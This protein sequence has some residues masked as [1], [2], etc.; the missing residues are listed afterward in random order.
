[1]TKFASATPKD[2]GL[3]SRLLAN[4][5]E[6]THLIVATIDVSKLT[7][8][9]DTGDVEPTV[10]VLSVEIVNTADQADAEAMYRRALEKRSGRTV[11]EG[12]DFGGD[13]T[14][15][16]V[17]T[18]DIGDDLELLVQAAELIIS[19]QFASHSMLQRKL[20][21][22]FAKAGRLMDL[23]ESAGVVGPKDGSKARDCLVT[24][25]RMADAVAQLRGEG[26]DFSTGEVTG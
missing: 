25:D 11:L 6:A 20:R 18:D 15:R 9:V 8:D 26:I 22:G 24:V 7:T 1:M 13:V 3:S 12:I 14:V 23:L 21:V 10:R 19:T 4:N 5:P 2:H 17:S 16:V